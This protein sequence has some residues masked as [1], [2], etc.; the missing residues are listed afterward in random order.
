M[1]VTFTSCLCGVIQEPNNAYTIIENQI[2]FTTACKWSRW[3]IT[4]LWFHQLHNNVSFFNAGRRAGGL[5]KSI[6]K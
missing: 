6:F 1:R 2:T 3:F 4:V 5:C